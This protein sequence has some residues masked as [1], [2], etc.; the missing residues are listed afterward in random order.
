MV[1]PSIPAAPVA[2]DLLESALQ[3]V[4]VM[5]LVV[6]RVEPPASTLLGRAV[7]LALKDPDLVERVVSHS[8]HSRAR[9]FL[10]ASMK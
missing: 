5:D 6:A 3:D 1:W 8:G 7:E 4:P 9:P 10:Q 2:C